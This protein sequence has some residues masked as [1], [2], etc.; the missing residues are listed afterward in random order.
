ME[1]SDGEENGADADDYLEPNDFE[2]VY[3]NRPTLAN[4]IASAY[5]ARSQLAT[6]SNATPQYDNNDNA[7]AFARTNRPLPATHTYDNKF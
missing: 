7:I 5:G 4:E 3:D 6:S 1:V 2:Q